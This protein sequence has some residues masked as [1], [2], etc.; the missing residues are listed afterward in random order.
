MD[1]KVIARL[2]TEGTHVGE[3][4]GFPPPGNTFKVSSIFIFTVK[5]GK[6]VEARADGDTLGFYQQL[7]MELKPKEGEK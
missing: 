5:D 4:E 1:N 3:L 2:L 7:G 6:I